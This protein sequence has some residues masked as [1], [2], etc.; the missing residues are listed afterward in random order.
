LTWAFQQLRTLDEVLD[1]VVTAAVDIVPAARH[2]S[3]TLLEDDRSVQ[4]LAASSPVAR[5]IDAAQNM[6]AAGPCLDA[7]RNRHVVHLEHRTARRS[8]PAL[9]SVLLAHHVESVLSQPLLTPGGTAL[10][11]TLLSDR[12]PGF[13][14]SNRRTAALVCSVAALAVAGQVKSQEFQTALDSRDLIGQAKGILMERLHL[15]S[16]AA[17]QLMVQVS[18]SRH[19]KLREIAAVIAETGQSPDELA[20]AVA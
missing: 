9:S 17:F 4:T 13:D 2:A 18:Q 8:L 7:V 3:I 16:E 11:L 5:S 19:V 14:P 6:L 1:A 10:A 12:D 20:A 15:T